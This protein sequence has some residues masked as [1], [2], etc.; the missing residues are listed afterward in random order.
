M[1]VLSVWIGVIITITW[2]AEVLSV[3]SQS[4]FTETGL[5]PFD[6]VLTVSWGHLVQ[7]SQNWAIT[8]SIYKWL[9][10]EQRGLKFVTLRQ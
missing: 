2:L 4:V 7:V 9:T 5:G 3:Q 1:V 10:M 6:L 8:L